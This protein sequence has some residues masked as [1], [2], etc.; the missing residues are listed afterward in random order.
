MGDNS[1]IVEFPDQNETILRAKRLLFIIMKEA[2]PRTGLLPCQNEMYDLP[3]DKS[4][5]R[6]ALHCNKLNTFGKEGHGDKQTS[7]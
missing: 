3:R 1:L 6:V 4:P 7:V 5:E 2:R